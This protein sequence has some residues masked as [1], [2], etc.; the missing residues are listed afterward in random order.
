MATN[1][2]PY[3]SYRLL[4]RES[5]GTNF[6]PSEPR[7]RGADTGVVRDDH[8]E[9]APADRRRWRLIALI[10]VAALSV[11]S[12]ARLAAGAS[13]GVDSGALRIVAEEEREDALPSAPATA[14]RRGLDDAA[15]SANALPPAGG[16]WRDL[17]PAPLQTP[18]RHAAVWTGRELVAVGADGA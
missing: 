15:R 12:L 9:A 16:V 11:A 5:A 14:P 13:D 7:R 8:A 3:R 17:P 10:A 1:T 2:I 6:C 18:A 4:H